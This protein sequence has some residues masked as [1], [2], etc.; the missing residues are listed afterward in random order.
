MPGGRPPAPTYLVDINTILS[1]EEI[2]QEKWTLLQL[3]PILQENRSTIEFLAR[4]QLL[5]NTCLCE[6]CNVPCRL[7]LY[8]PLTDGYR[9]L[10]PSCKRFG[11]TI[12]YG[13]FFTRSHLPLQTIVFSMYWW[14]QGHS[15]KSLCHE[16]E[17][18]RRVAIDWYNFFRDISIYWNAEYPVRL[19]GLIENDGDICSLVV[20]LDETVLR[21]RKYNRGRITPSRWVFGG[22][23]RESGKCFV[24][25]VKN[26]RASTLLPLIHRYVHE[27]SH[28]ITDGFASYE[29]ISVSGVYA[30]SV[31]IHNENFIN[32]NDAAIHTQNIEN[33]WG[34]LKS[35]FKRMR[36][37]RKCLLRSYLADFMWTINFVGSRCKMSCLFYC[38]SKKYPVA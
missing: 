19:G 18:S 25:Y 31:V 33:L 36:G 9:W 6:D 23:D 30:H 38:V 20:E 7:N 3:S 21:R 37:T 27:G 13:S 1:D 26:R 34:R 15:I 32:P 14:S 10:C 2:I 35:G 4:R 11:R 16:V 29:N 12:R 8:S 22:I 28:I 24:E 5:R 17:I